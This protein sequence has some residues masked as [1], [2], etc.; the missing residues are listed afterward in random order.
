ML[1][2][3]VITMNSIEKAPIPTREERAEQLRV[4]ERQANRDARRDALGT[5]AWC[6]LWMCIGLFLFG[7]AL[8]STDQKWAPILALVGLLVN[9]VGVLVTLGFWFHRAQKRG[10]F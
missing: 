9:N 5:L 3:V 4:F 8:H 6:A 10:D 1:R 2:E 7:S